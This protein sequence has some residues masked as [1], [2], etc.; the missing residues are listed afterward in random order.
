MNSIK[1]VNGGAEMTLEESREVLQKLQRH[2]ITDLNSVEVSDA[3][4]KAICVL[5]QLEKEHKVYDRY[6]ERKNKND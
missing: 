5:W 2:E 3:L 6:M 1:R 4:D